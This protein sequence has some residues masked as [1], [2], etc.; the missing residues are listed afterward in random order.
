MSGKRRERE[1][2]RERESRDNDID[3]LFFFFA[4]P[5]LN[6][7]STPTPSSLGKLAGLDKKLSRSLDAEVATGC[8]PA[9]LSK[10]P[11]GPLSDAGERVFYFAFLI[12]LCRGEGR[13]ERRQT[14]SLARISTFS[15]PPTTT[16]TTTTTQ[17]PGG[18]SST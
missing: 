3:A 2:E 17:G 7:T 18:P 14:N 16:T 6:L 12:S 15:P 10:S 5:S 9:E 4:R 8:S 13:V 1:R 11:V